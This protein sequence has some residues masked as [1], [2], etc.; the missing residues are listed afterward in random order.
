MHPRLVLLYPALHEE[1][2]H[3]PA[4]H[5]TALTFSIA[6]QSV[7]SPST[8][9]PFSSRFKL[10]PP[11]DWREADTS[12]HSY[13]SFLTD[14]ESPLARQGMRPAGQARNGFLSRCFVRS[15]SFACA[16][17]TSSCPLLSI[18]PGTTP[19]CTLQLG[20]IPRQ[21]RRTRRLAKVKTVR[22]WKAE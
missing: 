17:N 2:S 14:S 13:T 6:V 19:A 8:K 5:S 4:L 12:T 22:I 1:I 21:E 20:S 18:L 11:Q 10:H 3:C 16:A 7:P 15:L 9:S